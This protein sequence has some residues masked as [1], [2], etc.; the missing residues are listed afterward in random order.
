[1]SKKITTVEQLRETVD[2]FTQDV[3]R[4]TDEAKY[5]EAEKVN[6]KLETLKALL[7][8]KEEEEL[9]KKHAISIEELKQAYEEKMNKFNFEWDET[10]TKFENDSATLIKTTK[11]KQNRQLAEL[12]TEF[13]TAAETGTLP[14][15]VFSQECQLLREQEKQLGKM[16]KFKEAQRTKMAADAMEE[17]EINR[18]QKGLEK[19][20]NDRIIQLKKQMLFEL[21]NLEK[22]IERERNANRTKRLDETAQLEQRYKNMQQEQARKNRTELNEFHSK[23]AKLQFKERSMASSMVRTSARSSPKKAGPKAKSSPKRQAPH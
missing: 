12:E 17:D 20:N 9:K 2:Q 19:R 13:R 22:T 11:E 16:K 1:M 23:R 7:Y 15:V 4:L 6:S 5:E 3:E 14:P 18:H 21:T 8:E 10:M